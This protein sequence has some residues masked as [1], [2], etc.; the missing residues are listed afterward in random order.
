MP[1]WSR[2]LTAFA[3]FALVLSAGS[4]SPDASQAGAPQEA[5]LVAAL[6]A[7][8]SMWNRGDLEGFIAPYDAATT[9]MTPAGPI[10]KEA[11]RARYAARYF[12][13]GQPDQQLRFEQLT[14]RA[15]GD[16]HA[17]MTGRFALTGGGK[18]DQSGWFTLVWARTPSG[19][20]IVHDHSS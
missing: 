2:P 6:Q 16:T 11:M 5:E 13:G 20:R 4:R 12:T 1:R 18:A 7:T 8:T 9:F 15:L 3:A 14:V 10:G 19:W 17:L